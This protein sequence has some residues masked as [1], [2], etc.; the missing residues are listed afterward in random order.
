MGIVLFQNV[1]NPPPLNDIFLEYDTHTSVMFRLNVQTVVS[2][3]F[4]NIHTT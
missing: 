1:L 2:D 3:P 4:T